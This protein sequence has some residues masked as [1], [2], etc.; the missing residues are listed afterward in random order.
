[1]IGHDAYLDGQVSTEAEK[2]H[3]VTVAEG[4]APVRVRTNLIRVVPKGVFS[5]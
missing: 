3:A 2:E 4:A 5:F 1:V